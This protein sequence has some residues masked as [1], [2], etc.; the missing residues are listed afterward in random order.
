MT[1]RRKASKGRSYSLDNFGDSNNYLIQKPWAKL[2]RI[3]VEL[4]HAIL[5]YYYYLPLIRMLQTILT[6][7]GSKISYIFYLS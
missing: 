1:V 6:Q 7:K 5:I 4:C 3:C 2:N